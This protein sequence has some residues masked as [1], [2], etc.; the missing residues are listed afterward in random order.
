MGR[1]AVRAAAHTSVFTAHVRLSLLHPTTGSSAPPPQTMLVD[2]D[3]R[4]RTVAGGPPAQVIATTRT[5]RLRI[6]I[7]RGGRVTPSTFRPPRGH[8]SQVVR[9]LHPGARPD[10]AVAA[11]WLGPAWMGHRARSSSAASGHGGWYSIGD[12]HV[13]VE[14]DAPLGGYRG[15]RPV[16]L[17]DGSHATLQ[18]AALRP[19][20]TVSPS[21]APYAPCSAAFARRYQASCASRSSRIPSRAPIRG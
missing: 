13:D 6:T 10:P 16:T 21:R 11:C 14:V 17:E 7:R 19:D 18:V 20:G 4:F 3:G 5:E 12:P 2:R 1:P 9:Q 8:A 15:G